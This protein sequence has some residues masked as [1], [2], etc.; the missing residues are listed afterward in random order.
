MND[1]RAVADDAVEAVRLRLAGSQDP[2]LAAQARR[3]E[4]LFDEQRDLVEVEGLVRIVIGAGLH[5]LD[6]DIDAGKCGE[7]N[8]ERVRVRLLHF[9]QNGEP[10]GV[11]QPVIEQDEVDAFAVLLQRF[12]GGLRLEH[13]I[14]FVR[15]PIVQ[16][17]ANQLLVINDQNR[18]FGHVRFLSLKSEAIGLGLLD[19]RRHAFDFERLAD[20]AIGAERLRSLCEFR[21]V[22]R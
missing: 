15:E 1:G 4:R 10:V 22:V 17:P 21:A 18:R 20:D 13:A 7:E 19:E 5:R 6:R 11:R 9:F 14:A 12:G 2:H 8:D 16:R 3:L